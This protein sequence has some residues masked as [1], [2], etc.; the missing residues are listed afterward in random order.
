MEHVRALVAK[1]LL[2]TFVLGLFLGMYE[3]IDVAELLLQS[4]ILTG[5]AYVLGD[6][7]IL[8]TMGNTAATVADFG[9]AWLA[10]WIINE[11]YFLNNLHWSAYPTAA[12]F[13]AAG[14]FFFHR[15]VQQHVLGRER[16]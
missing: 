14:E 8:P 13:I 9:L 11:N 3:R 16:V 4:L 2:T 1:Y 5:I 15:F 6:L 7:F 10:L 12:F